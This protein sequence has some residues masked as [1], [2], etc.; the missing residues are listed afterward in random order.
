MKDIDTAQ[1]AKDIYKARKYLGKPMKWRFSSPYE[2]DFTGHTILV[3]VDHTT[4]SSSSALVSNEFN[5][6]GYCVA[7]IGDIGRV[8]PVNN[9]VEESPYE[10]VYLNENYKARV[11]A[12]K[13]M[14]DGNEFPITILQE[15]RLAHS[16]VL[17]ALSD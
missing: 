3:A 17:E 15:L 4:A 1:L 7:L 8:I 6:Q 11:F 14:V 16:D 10:D 9:L 12:D 13:I 5:K 2:M